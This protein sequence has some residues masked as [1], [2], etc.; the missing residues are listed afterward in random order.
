MP[1]RTKRTYNLSTATVHRVRELAE[2]YGAARTQDG[3]VELAIE[4]LYHEARARVEAEQWA[5][6][7]VDQEFRSEMADIAAAFDEPD[8][9]PT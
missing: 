2:Q 8:S 5:D 7:A 3:V 9:W 1:A 4:R 6:A